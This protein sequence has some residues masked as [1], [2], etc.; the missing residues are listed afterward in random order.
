MSD[1]DR[2]LP[3]YDAQASAYAARNAEL[4]EL[5]QAQSFVAAL[6]KQAHILDLGC[7]PGQYASWFAAQGFRVEAWDGSSEMLTLAA[8]HGGVTTRLA[9]FE[10][11]TNEA[12]FDGIWANFSLLHA[13][14]SDLPDLLARIHRA[15]TPSGVFHI[16]M[17]LGTGAGPD[18]IGRY[19]TYYGEAELEDLLSAADFKIMEK[20]LFDGVGL[21]GTAGHYI[22]LLCHG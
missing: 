4:Y 12:A 3:I 19:Y 17:K 1:A 7:G 14:R 10:D 11:L 20:H 2:T 9:R 8:Q 5:P 16:A 15:L 21:D 13:E 18:K 22:T 6:P